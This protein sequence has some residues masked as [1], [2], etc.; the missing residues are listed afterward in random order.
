MTYDRFGEQYRWQL[1]QLWSFAGGDTQTE[2]NRDR[3]TLFPVVFYQKSSDTNENYWAVLPLYGHV[4]RRLFR[5]DVWFAAMPL[6]VKSRKRDVYTWNYL[7]P[8]FHVRRGNNLRGWQALPLIGHQ[9]KGMTFNTNGF[10]DA[11][12]IGGHDRWFAAWPVYWSQRNEIGTTNEQRNIGFLPAYTALRSPQ[13]DMTSVLW[14]LFTKIEDRERKYREWQGPWPLVAFAR[15]EGKTLDR[16]LPFYSKG[17]TANIETRAYAWPIYKENRFTTEISDRKRSRVLFFLYSH[18]RES[19]KETGAARKRVDL[20]PVFTWRQDLNGG[21]RL[22]VLALFEPV[23][24]N[25]KSIERNY[26]PLWSLWR[27]ERNPRTG[28]SSQSLLWNLYRKDVSP[29]RKKTSLLFGLYRYVKDAEGART[30]LFYIPFGSS[31]AKP[32][33]SG[34]TASGTN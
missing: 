21:T 2:T 14:P 9:M 15:G 24:A 34:K 17:K 32:A 10:G 13:R 11:T 8:I 7:F 25:N 27:D 22:Q 4:Q 26:S 3:F 29:E 20:W 23:L 16:V 12:V 5:D 33:A 18:I 1:F 28:A 6:Y 30:R 31:P 19:S